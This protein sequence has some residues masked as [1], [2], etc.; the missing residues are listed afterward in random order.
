MR[1]LVI[2]DQLFFPIT[3]EALGRIDKALPLVGDV[4]RLDTDQIKDLAVY[5]CL[6][7][8]SVLMHNFYLHLSSVMVTVIS[9]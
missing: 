3:A 8:F 4:L 1:V 2:K 6:L 5:S 7:S 9:N